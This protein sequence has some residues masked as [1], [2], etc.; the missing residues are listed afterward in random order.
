MKQCCV[1]APTI[2][3]SVGQCHYHH[4]KTA[5]AGKQKSQRAFVIFSTSRR[6]WVYQVD[7]RHTVVTITFA[8]KGEIR[9]FHQS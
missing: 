2:R 3:E 5:A 1:L 4:D 6:S 9:R 8:M 7:A